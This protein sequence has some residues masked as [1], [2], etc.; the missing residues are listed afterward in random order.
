MQHVRGVQVWKDAASGS[1]FLSSTVAE[2]KTH[3][4]SRP[5]SP[6]DHAAT[7]QSYQAE[8]YLSLQEIYWRSLELQIN[9]GSFPWKQCRP[10]AVPDERDGSRVGNTESQTSN[11]TWIVWS[12][13]PNFWRLGVTLCHEIEWFRVGSMK[14]HGWKLLNITDSK[15]ALKWQ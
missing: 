10:E 7:S 1:R 3:L 12:V 8:R 14:S 4:Q 13:L 15:A 9:A 6:P 11:T 5:S 2:K